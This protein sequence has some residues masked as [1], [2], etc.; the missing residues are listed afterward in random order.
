MHRIDNASSAEVMPDVGPVGP[1]PNGFFKARDAQAGTPGTKVDASFLNTVQEE[2]CNVVTGAG[3]TLSKSSRNQVYLAIQALIT[4]AVNNVSP[5]IL[6]TVTYNSHGFVKGDLVYFNGTIWLKARANTLASSWNVGMVYEVQS[7]NVFKL[8]LLG[9]ISGLSGLTAG[10]AYYVSVT[11]AGALQSSRPAGNETNVIK[12][13]F[14]ADSTTS[15][16]F[17]NGSPSLG[18]GGGGGG[19]GDL[20]AANNLSDLD[21]IAEARDNLELGSAALEDTSAFIESDVLETL[22]TIEYV[23][24]AIDDLNIADYATVADLAGE[25]SS[26]ETQIATKAATTYVDSEI[27]GVQASIGGINSTVGGILSDL[28]TI[29]GDI[30]DLET[31]LTNYATLVY[32]D[33][34]IDTVEGLIA[35]VVTDIGTINSTISDIQNDITAI[36]TDYATTASVTSGLATKQDLDATLTN[37]AALS[38][39]ADKLPY[40]TNTDTFA[41]ADFSAFARTLIDDADASTMRATLG[42]VIG[43]NVQAF[44]VDLQAIAGLTSAADKGIQFTGAGTAGT[45][46]LTAFAKTILDDADQAAVQTTLGLVIGTNVQAYDVELAA[47]AGLTSAANKLPYYTGSGTAAL[48]DFTSNARTF[49]ALAPS[50]DGIAF[51]DQSATSYAFLSLSGDLDLTNTTLSSKGRLPTTEVTGTSQSAAVNTKYIA[52]NAS[53]VTITL[54]GTAAVG[55]EIH[56]SGKGAGLWTVALASGQNMVAGSNTGTTTTGTLVATQRYDSC[57]LECLT[58]NTVWKVK[59]PDGLLNL[60]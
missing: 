53:M 20:L 15:G 7:T 18:E 44:D 25:V 21:D 58:A 12:P 48:A 31:D 34:E 46:D 6:K 60:T 57:I 24:D 29:Q 50:S 55:D 30:S 22:A 19:G 28:G 10:T 52:N 9:Y 54:P 13:V 11:T 39:A 1:N 42:L 33:D 8:L 43:T 36:E 23:D 45:Y 16:Y 40:G 26:L 37:F 59:S 5:T 41:L 47:L 56:I 2:L 27:D 51:W 4:G 3:I 17:I 49:T 14:I 32:V 35:D 38:I